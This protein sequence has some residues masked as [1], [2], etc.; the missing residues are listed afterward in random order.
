[1]NAKTLAEL[2]LKVWA[3]LQLISAAASVPVFVLFGLARWKAEG[4][5]AL[6][7]RLTQHTNTILLVTQVVSGIAVLVWADRI[8][9]LFEDDTTPLQLDADRSDLQ[10]LAFAVLGVFFLVPGLENVAAAA[11]ALWSVPSSW[12]QADT[13]SVVW[14]RQGEAIVRG[15]VQI[16]AGVVLVFGRRGIAR[17]WSRMR[18]QRLAVDDEPAE[19]EFD[20]GDVRDVGSEEAGRE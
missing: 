7:L 15:V 3:V 20:D 4:E 17:T 6:I 11:F 2:A 5:G 8:V 19:D 12:N 10:S 14:E 13:M 1:M 9:A 18:G 16:G